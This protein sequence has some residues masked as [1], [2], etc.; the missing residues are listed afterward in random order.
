VKSKGVLI[1]DEDRAPSTV[2]VREAGD[3]YRLPE[4]RREDRMMNRTW[5]TIGVSAF[6]MLAVLGRAGPSRR[7]PAA[8]V[9]KAQPRSVGPR[10]RAT[11]S[12]H[13][14]H[15]SPRTYDRPLPTRA[16]STTALISPSAKDR[17]RVQR[18]FPLVSVSYYSDA[19]VHS[20]IALLILP[21][22]PEARM[23]TSPS[24]LAPSAP[25]WTRGLASATSRSGCTA[26]AA[27]C[28]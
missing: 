27:T 7:R 9:R 23:S 14:L 17:P 21:F 3:H 2:L 24:D 12:R 13:P 11:R 10:R 16:R 4:S 1:L 26:R 6:V 15:A 22:D 5:R 25:G 18:P 19:P 8:L 28:N 20:A